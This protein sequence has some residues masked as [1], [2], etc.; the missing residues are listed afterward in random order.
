MA[1]DVAAELCRARVLV[2]CHDETMSASGGL[3]AAGFDRADEVL[4][5]HLLF[6]P[7]GRHEPVVERCLADGYIEAPGL[8]SDPPVPAGTVAVAV[9]RLQRVDARS[10]AHERAI[11]GSMTARHGGEFGGW[12]VLAVPEEG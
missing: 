5:R 8:S 10:L 11:I 3:A 1:R 6:V 12:A 7:P 4:L 2:E 9:A